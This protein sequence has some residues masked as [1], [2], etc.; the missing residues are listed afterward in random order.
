MARRTLATDA[1]TR[2]DENPLAGSWST[3]STLTNLQVVSNAVEAAAIN[4]A[5][6]NIQSHTVTLPNDQWA[7]ATIA[8]WV[9]GATY[10]SAPIGLRWAAP[11]TISG[12]LLIL[13]KTN[14]P[15]DT[16]RLSIQKYTAA[17]LSQVTSSPSNFVNITLAGNDVFRLEAIGTLLRGFQNG[18]LVLSGTEASYAGGRAAVEAYAAT[19]LSNA[20]WNSFRSGDFV[21]PPPT[22][23]AQL[24][25]LLAQ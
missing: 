18:V 9:G 1:F 25:P 10:A 16:Y 4:T 3:Y 14:S 17:V 20:A 6:D 19:S 5:I 7:Q 13:D 22:P 12:Y 2:A 11:N 24:A 8:S 21:L 15:T 23:W